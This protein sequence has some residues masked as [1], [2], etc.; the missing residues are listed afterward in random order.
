MIQSSEYAVAAKEHSID[1]VVT[2]PGSKSIANRALV[3]AALARGSSTIS[4]LPDGDDTQAMLQSLERLGASIIRD[5]EIA[6]FEQQIDLNREDAVTVNANLAGTTARFLTSVGAL[7]KG[8]LTVT[9]NES[10]RGRPMK[11]LHLALGQMGAGVS[12]QGEK[13]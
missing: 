2:V 8:P 12:W 4:G 5:G 3:C 6:H 9:G 11:D 10:L 13:Y 7:R 1:A